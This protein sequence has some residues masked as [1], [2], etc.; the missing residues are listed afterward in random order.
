MALDERLLKG[1]GVVAAIVDSGS[2]AG[3]GELLDMSQSGVSRAVARLET[4]IGTRLFDRSTHSVTMTDE[5]RRFYEQV[6]PLLGSL[7]E[8]VSSVTAGATTVRGRVRVNIDAFFSRQMLA[9]RLGAFIERHPE[10]ALELVARDQLGDMVAEGFD[11]AVRFGHPRDS[12]LIGR[13]LLETRML[14]VAA[15][16]YLKKHGRP[17]TPDA[18][19]GGRHV[20]IQVRDPATGRPYLWE[21]HAGRRKQAFATTGQLTVSDAGTLHSVCL[22]GHGIARIKALGI[23]QHL[24]EGRLIDLF[25]D[26][27]DERFPLYAYY[28]SRRHVPAKV[29]SFLDFIISV[30]EASKS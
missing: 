26:W 6:F 11:L 1:M 23:A 7:E 3:A 14:T 2:F 21:F 20:C 10:L 17:K 4:R 25:P 8:A 12:A 29:R 18:L 19:K 24:A 9:P 5:G 22:A 28:P 13:K 15:P 27:P 16:S 30:C